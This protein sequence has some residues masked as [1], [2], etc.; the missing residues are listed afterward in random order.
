MVFYKFYASASIYKP[1]LAAKIQIVSLDQNAAVQGLDIL[2]Q[3][4]F[5]ATIQAS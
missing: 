3:L 1:H 2:H 5:S 4:V